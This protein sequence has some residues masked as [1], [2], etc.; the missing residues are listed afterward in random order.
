[1]GHQN[2]EEQRLV[3]KILMEKMSKLRNFHHKDHSLL[4]I[5]KNK[6]SH[7]HHFHKPDVK[8]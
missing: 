7:D 6:F 1:M 2:K 3:D 4:G 5:L 8:F